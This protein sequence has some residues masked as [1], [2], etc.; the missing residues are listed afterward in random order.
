M[1]NLLPT[2][3]ASFGESHKTTILLVDDH[4]M[5]RQSLRTILANQPDFVVV[6]E[7]DNGE[8]AVKLANEF[9]PD[10]IV[11]DIDL[12]KLDGLEATKMIKAAN[13][14]IAILVLTV[15]D[16]EQHILGIL[17]AGAAGY[18]TKSVYSDMF[19][20]AIRGIITGDMVFSPV[21]GQ[22]LLKHAAHYPKKEV[23]LDAVEKLS[24]REL[25]ILKLAAR[26][27][28][29]KEIAQSLGISLRTVKG[30]LVDVFSKLRVGSR[31]EAI[32]TSLRAGVITLDEIQ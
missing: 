23:Q 25:E 13:P 31:T 3:D 14:E 9:K 15:S 17:Q 32:I 19:V 30:H 5:L 10:I 6:A 4:P 21:I 12:P 27:M 26:G 20:Q 1:F 24:I 29:N 11:M 22:K 8:D 7:A 28:S 16:A 2:S 18:L